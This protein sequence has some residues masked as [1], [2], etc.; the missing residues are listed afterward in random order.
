MVQGLPRYSNGQDMT[1]SCGNRRFI[2]EFTTAR[3]WDLCW[4]IWDQSTSSQTI[5]P[6]PRI[7]AYLTHDVFEK[8]FSWNHNPPSPRKFYMPHT[9]NYDIFHHPNNIHEV[10]SFLRI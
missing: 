8:H 6:N 2:V 9:Y 7:C 3:Y 10:E 4:A 1:C 5:S